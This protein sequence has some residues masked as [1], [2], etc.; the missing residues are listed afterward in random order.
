MLFR[1]ANEAADACLQGVASAEDIDRAMMAGVNYPRGPLDWA[2]AIG[3]ARVL[4]VLANL[5]DAYGDDRYRPSQLLARRVA[6]RS[7][8]H[9]PGK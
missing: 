9:D 1:S 3:P 5:Q 4:D 2:D 6:A 7:T 8:F